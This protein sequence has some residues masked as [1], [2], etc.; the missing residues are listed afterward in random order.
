M[1]TLLATTRITS[2]QSTL[3]QRTQKRTYFNTK[4]IMAST[5]AV[6][7]WRICAAYIL[8]FEPVAS[9][10]KATLAIRRFYPALTQIMAFIRF[11]NTH[12]LLKSA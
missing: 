1:K 9:V 11:F 12:L 7:T 8:R 2:K 4:T 6:L 10:A 5:T 3:K